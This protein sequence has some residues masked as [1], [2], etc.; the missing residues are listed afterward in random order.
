M[1][2]GTTMRCVLKQPAATAFA[3]YLLISADRFSEVLKIVFAGAVLNMVSNFLVIP[4]WGILGAAAVAGFTE[5]FLFFMLLN[6]MNLISERIPIFS[7]LGKPVLAAGVMGVVLE[8]ISWPL[9]PL[10]LAGMGI[11]F[12]TLYFFRAF[13]EQDFLVVKNIFK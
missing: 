7:L 9:I 10:I 11:Y 2:S 6:C 12:L 1:V 13:N 5:L 8:Q 3:I 4:K